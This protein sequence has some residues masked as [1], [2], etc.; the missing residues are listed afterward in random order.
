V[1]LLTKDEEF[2]LGVAAKRWLPIEQA[3]KDLADAL[4]RPPSTEVSIIS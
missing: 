3:K 4:G 2:E 1:P